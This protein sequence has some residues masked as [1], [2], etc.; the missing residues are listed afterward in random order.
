[1]II[2]KSDLIEVG[3]ECVD[4][5]Q[6]CYCAGYCERENETRGTVWPA[7]LVSASQKR[8]TAALSWFSLL[9]T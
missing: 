3:C 2:L 5:L 7:E 4:W 6:M 1:M 8:L 9:W